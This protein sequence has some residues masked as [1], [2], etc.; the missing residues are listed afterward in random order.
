MASI[1]FLRAFVTV[2]ALCAAIIASPQSE[3]S[4]KRLSVADTHL[5]RVESVFFANYAD[6]D[7]DGDEATG[8]DKRSTNI[9]I[10]FAA[11]ADEDE[12][13]DEATGADKLEGRSL[14]F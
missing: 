7:E 3:T 12:D 6:E 14:S 1:I 2:S 5:P 9:G 4:F 10:F 11:Y 13:G 8:A